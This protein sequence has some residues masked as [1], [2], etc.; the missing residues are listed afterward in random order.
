MAAVRQ[1]CFDTETTGLS[2]EKGDRLIEIGAVEII[3]RTVIRD[4]N[5]HV[6]INPEREVPDEAVAIHGITTEFLAD[7]PK[8]A[9]VVDGFLE[10]IKGAEIIAH[11][12]SF[13]VG[14]INS[15][16]KRLK[17]G[18]VEDYCLRVTDSLE[19]ARK[20]FPGAKN[21][22][23]AL[24]SRFD[25]DLSSRNAGHG[26]LIDSLL[27]GEVYLALTREQHE[28]LGES[29]AA[30]EAIESIPP[31]DQFLV[32]EIPPEELA[33]HTDYLAMIDKK[34]KGKCLW[35]K[36]QTPALPPAAS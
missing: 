19:M 20:N 16:L 34:S 11:N 7:K 3:D 26:A 17:R 14:F 23:D 25:I 31:A 24:C 33:V 27:L 5:F 12:A 1:I 9:D 35:L 36:A 29:F 2:H 15:E 18:K 8:F 21:T 13:D 28:L 30:G 32:S 22:V 4:R 6:Y 10:F